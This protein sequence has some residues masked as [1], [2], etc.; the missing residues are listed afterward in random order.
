[1]LARDIMSSPVISV[2]PEAPVEEVAE[3]MARHR[4]GGV[5]VVDA[6]ERLLGIVGESDLLYRVAHPHLPPYVEIL[7]S[8]IFLEPPG[9]TD[10]MVKKIVAVQARDIMNTRVVTVTEETPVEDVADLMI[11]RKVRRV[12]VLRQGRPVGVVTRGDIV[13]G[14]LAGRLRQAGET[15]E[16]G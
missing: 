14:V 9:K 6:Q 1:M 3:L 16:A 15:R 13:R 11:E 5:A 10:E 7:G 12:V 4:I 8:I 2:P